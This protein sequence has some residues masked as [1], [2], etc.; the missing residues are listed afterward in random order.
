[1][2]RRRRCNMGAAR[3][4]RPDCARCTGLFS[5]AIPST[6]CGSMEPCSPTAWPIT[7]PTIS[8][9]CKDGDLARLPAPWGIIMGT[10]RFIA[11]TWYWCEWGENGGSDGDDPA[12]GCNG[13]D[14]PGGRGAS[15]TY[16]RSGAGEPV[17]RRRRQVLEQVAASLDQAA[18]E[19]LD[20][21]A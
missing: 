11:I 6:C 3:C 12:G 19:V 2:A 4:C 16:G 18:A 8:A 14:R 15:R 17:R 21:N 20:A 5:A 10:R 13:R 1:M 7:A 9:A